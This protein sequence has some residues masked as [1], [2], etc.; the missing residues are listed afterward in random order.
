MD[1]CRS[2][3]LEIVKARIL[4]HKGRSM[5]KRQEQWQAGIPL[6]SH[7]RKQAPAGAAGEALLLD[8]A[9]VGKRKYA[10]PQLIPF[11]RVR[12]VTLGGSPGYGDSGANFGSTNF[13]TDS[14]QEIPMDFPK[15][16]P[17]A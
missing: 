11:G 12:D 17:E 7:C 8:D 14:S 9:R 16:P 5:N 10:T 13:P 6:E 3:T 2:R 4:G 15:E 1:V